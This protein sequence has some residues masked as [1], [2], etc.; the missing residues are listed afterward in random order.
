MRRCLVATSTLL[1][2]A[3]TIAPA[4]ADSGVPAPL[5]AN[6]GRAPTPAG[7]TAAIGPAARAALARGS[8]LIV[9]PATGTVLYDLRSGVARVPASNAKLAT[10]VAALTVLGP[11]SRIPT[12]V[13]VSDTDVWLVGGGDPTLASAAGA[14]GAPTLA[15]LATQT[16]AQV[17]A[18]STL[19]LHYDATAFRGPVLAPGWK[20]SYPAVGEVA[21]V[22]ALMVDQ[23][24]RTPR[25]KSRVADPARRAATVFAGLLRRAGV[26]VTSVDASAAP[27]DATTVAT[28]MSPPV[29]RIVQTMLTDSE[30]TYAEALGHLVGAKASH[31]PTFAGGAAATRAALASLKL[32]VDG[33]G[34]VD[35]SGL[36]TQDRLTARTLAAILS[37]VVVGRTPALASIAPGLPVAGLTGTL[38]DRYRTPATLSGRGYVHA[39]TGTLT[40]VVAESG[41]VLDRTGRQLVFSFLAPKVGSLNAARETLDTL[42]STLATCGCGS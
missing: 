12:T 36:S 28:V 9:D 11:T 34:L 20:A 38:A 22:V 13:K 33:Y 42:A 32:P 24:R 27:A 14:P 35:A 4:W 18:H 5:P 3:L 8:A 17:G 37:T 2:F 39:K 30:N 23:G 25:G 40:G 6:A 10:A 1:A 19:R 16:I 15:D 7:V 26:T 29:S 31:Q 21:P 41:I